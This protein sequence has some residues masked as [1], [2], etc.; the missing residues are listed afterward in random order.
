MPFFSVIIPTYN[1]RDAVRRAVGSVLSQTMKDYE[2]IVIDDGST[3][4][5]EESLGEFGGS[6][7]CISQ[8]HAGVSAARNR[9]ISASHGEH[10]VFLD[11]DDLWLPDKLFEQQRYILGNP[12]TRIH[13]TDEI[14]IRNG[15]R[16]NPKNRHRKREGFIFKE[17]LELCLISPSAVAME[18]GLFDEYGLF[19]ENLP[20]CEDYDLWLRITAREFVGLLER[21]L[22]IRHGGHADQLSSRYWG[23]DRYRV[24]AIIKLLASGSLRPDE[25]LIECAKTVL[26]EKCIILKEGAEKRGN[27]DFARTIGEI[28]RQVRGGRY[29][30]IDYQSLAAGED[31]PS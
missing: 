22:V 7:R 17:S 3:D 9:G 19:D 29:S 28:I 5:T 15:R 4:G 16:V 31:P 11:S 10:L 18:R 6:I 12:R 8:E 24:F 27:D 13:Q 30:S 21:H 26:L 25:N 2:I 14:W 23:M 20:A 1:R